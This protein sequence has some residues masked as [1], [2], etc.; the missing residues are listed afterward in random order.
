MTGTGM[1][2]R[3]NPGID[4]RM[5][6]AILHRKSQRQQYKTNSIQ[7]LGSAVRRPC[8]QMSSRDYGTNEEYRPVSIAAKR[9]R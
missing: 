1:A 8:R 7:S 6:H 4:S 9:T 3:K 2:G 5:L